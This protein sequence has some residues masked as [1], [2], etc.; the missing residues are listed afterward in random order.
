MV[1]IRG[2]R[3]SPTLLWWLGTGALAA[4]LLAVSTPVAV[5]AYDVPALVAFTAATLQA[6]SLPLASVRPRDATVL[7]FVGVVGFSLAIPAGAGPTWPLTVPG[8][9]TLILFVGLVAAR[10]PWRPAATTWWASVLLLILLVLIDPRG[11][12][13]DDAMV[14]VSVYL[15]VSLVLV[16]AVVLL[17]NRAGVRRELG[18]ARRDVEL[19]QSR[20]AMAEERTRIARELHDVVAHGMSVIH[21][22]ASS[23]AYRI[24]DIDPESRAEFDRISAGA[25]TTIRE[26]RQLLSVLRDENADPSLTPVPG[27]DRLTELVE[28]TRRAGPA[29]TL[30]APPPAELDALPDTVGTAAYRIVQESLSNVLRHAAG[31]PARVTLELTPDELVIEVVNAAA[32]SPS[33]PGGPPGHGLHGMRERVRLLDGTLETRPTDDGGYRVSAR[34][35]RKKT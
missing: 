18:E 8:L 10:H 12:T 31:A 28:S 26:M 24:T 9:I 34:L 33:P 22:Q 15:P 35:P 6:A 21:M 23:A 25:R 30:T 5:E 20:R 32:G 3:A 27:L 13:I 19:E 4:I 14:T 2:R 29:V 1:A 17:R 16:G 7:Q 11:R